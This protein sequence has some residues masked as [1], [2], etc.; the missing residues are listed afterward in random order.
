MID[1]NGIA[2]SFDYESP[3]IED[4]RR[5]LITLY[6]IREGE[7]PLDRKLGLNC[8]FVGDMLPVAQNKFALEVARKTAQYEPRA[9]V[10]EVTY[11]QDAVSGNLIPTVHLTRGG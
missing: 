1:I 11:K 8:D 4:I 9:R 7:Q 5:C 2:L 3:E 6:G 10:R